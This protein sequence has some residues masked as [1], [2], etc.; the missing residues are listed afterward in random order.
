MVFGGDD[1]SVRV[2]VAAEEHHAIH[3][4]AE[5]LAALMHF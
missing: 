1:D 2:C 4:L 5:K 3:V